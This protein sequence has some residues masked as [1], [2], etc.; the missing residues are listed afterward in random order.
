VFVG[1]FTAGKLRIATEETR[2]CIL[3]EAPDPKFVQSVEHRTF[4]GA[5]AASRHQPVLYCD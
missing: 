4:S 1:T 2:L 3:V 5:Y